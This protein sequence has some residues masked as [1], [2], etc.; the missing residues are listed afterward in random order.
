MK[1]EKE[2]ATHVGLFGI[3]HPINRKI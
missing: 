2:S 3:T 1:N